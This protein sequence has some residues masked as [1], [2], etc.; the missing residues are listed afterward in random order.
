M[1]PTASLMTEK[2]RATKGSFISASA[3]RKVKARPIAACRIDSGTARGRQRDAAHRI[4]LHAAQ[5]VVGVERAEDVALVVAAEQEARHNQ[6]ALT[7]PDDRIAH[8]AFGVPAVGL[9]LEQLELGRARVAAAVA[10]AGETGARGRQLSC[11]RVALPVRH[12][13]LWPGQGGVSWARPRPVHRRTRCDPHRELA[14]K[15]FAAAP[16]PNSQALRN[17]ASLESANAAARR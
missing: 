15:R 8:A 17:A 12:V 5:L 6:V 13:S 14:E 9:V 11:P 2:A 3:V 16:R 7:Q 10:G 4:Q 1:A